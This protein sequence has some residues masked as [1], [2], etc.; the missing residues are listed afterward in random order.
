M[1]QDELSQMRELIK[2][3]DMVYAYTDGSSLNN[4]GLSGV[5]VAFTGVDLMTS[6]RSK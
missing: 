3:H 1:G 6:T 4:P 5:G 2:K